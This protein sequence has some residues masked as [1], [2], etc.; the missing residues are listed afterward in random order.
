MSR[1][2][3]MAGCLKHDD[4]ADALA[5]GVK[6]FT[7]AVAISAAKASA[8]RRYEEWKAMEEAF[9]DHP[10][11]ACDILVK[12]GTFIDKKFPSNTVYDW[13]KGR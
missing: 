7:D 9:T 1:L 8:A 3:K 13:T 2:R 10:H 11:A 12:G 6:W 5:Q 4:R